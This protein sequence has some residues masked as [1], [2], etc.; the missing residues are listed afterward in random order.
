MNQGDFR[1]TGK[2]AL[3]LRRR[4]TSHSLAPM[5]RPEERLTNDG[6]SLLHHGKLQAAID[7]CTRALQ[8]NLCYIDAY[9]CRG[10][11]YLFLGAYKKSIADFTS[12][13]RWKPNH[14]IAHN[15]LGVTYLSQEGFITSAI[16]H[17]TISI[18]SKRR[19][20][21]ALLN[22]AAAYLHSDNPLKAIDDITDAVNIN[23]ENYIA[24]IFL[25]IAHRH[26]GAWGQAIACFTRA[27]ELKPG[28]IVT[29]DPR[30]H[31]HALSYRRQ[32]A[33][34]HYLLTHCFDLKK[35]ISSSTHATDYEGRPGPQA[36]IS[37]A[38][39]LR[40]RVRQERVFHLPPSPDETTPYFPL[41]ANCSQ[42][43]TIACQAYLTHL[44][45][46]DCITADMIE[47]LNAALRICRL[48]IVLN[49]SQNT[50]QAPAPRRRPTAPGLFP[51]SQAIIA[52]PSC[53]PTAAFI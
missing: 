45:L 10:N 39:Q 26:R 12:A 5:I 24:Y 4:P 16:E 2:A 8:F 42:L 32:D 15:N 46:N 13:A 6:K 50:L 27:Y 1:H 34:W 40:I 17:F 29:Y 25:G 18:A 3:R 11:A 44:A 9:I 20:V 36:H 30:R 38:G 21:M 49:L 51:A 23:P 53:E 47:H 19:N 7:K 43:T 22:R 35:I 14:A 41:Y 31:S 48:L 28:F 37:S 52:K 33:E